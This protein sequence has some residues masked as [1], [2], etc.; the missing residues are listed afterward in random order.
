MGHLKTTRVG[1]ENERLAEF[2]LSRISFIATPAKNSDDVGSDFICALFR[3]QEM[4]N[5]KGNKWIELFP[6][7][8]FAIQVK[9][10]SP[11]KVDVSRHIEYLSSL[12][13]PFFLGFVE[14]EHARLTVY[15]CHHLPA[16]FSSVGRGLSNLSIEP[17]EALDRDRAYNDLNAASRQPGDPVCIQAVK[18]A[19]LNVNDTSATRESVSKMIADQCAW[20]LRD[21]AAKFSDHHVFM[22]DREIYFTTACVGS[23]ES[24]RGNFAA[25]L[26]EAFNN[27]HWVLLHGADKRAVSAEFEVY[28]TLYENGSHLGIGEFSIAKDAYERL[29]ASLA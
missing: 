21:L 19:D 4:T 10:G 11:T 20:T 7:H 9:T 18:V 23:F 14:Q 25:R 16:L 12:E 1:W 15:S 2:L 13:I 26:M 8:S 28:R 27:L 6:T 29:K 5:D 17:C 22:L 24:F 3:E